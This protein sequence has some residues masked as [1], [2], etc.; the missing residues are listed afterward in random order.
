VDA[1]MDGNLYWRT[2]NLKQTLIEIGFGKAYGTIR[3]ITLICKPK[4]Q[5]KNDYQNNDAIIKKFGLPE[6]KTGKWKKSFYCRDEIGDFFMS[7][8][9]NN[10]IITFSQHPIKFKVINNRIVFSFNR[11]KKLC[12][13]EIQNLNTDELQR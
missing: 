13:I 6:F 9:D 3:S 2:G 10:L 4:V 11:N 8:N 1:S 7:I 12:S 5:I